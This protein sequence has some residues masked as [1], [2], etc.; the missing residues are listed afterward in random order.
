MSRP[1]LKR[2]SGGRV[3][4]NNTSSTIGISSYEIHPLIEVREVGDRRPTPAVSIERHENKRFFYTFA[5]T[6][7]LCLCVRY[8]IFDVWSHS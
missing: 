3:S 4:F 2:T 6:S 5:I 8:A 1:F 7:I